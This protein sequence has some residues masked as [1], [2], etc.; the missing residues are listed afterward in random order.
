MGKMK[1]KCKRL[2]CRR[3]PAFTEDAEN[4]SVSRFIIDTTDTGFD[5]KPSQQ[6]TDHHASVAED[7]NHRGI[8]KENENSQPTDTSNSGS[9]YDQTEIISKD[10]DSLANGLPT[11]EGSDTQPREPP[12]VTAPTSSMPIPHTT[13]QTSTQQPPAQCTS[14]CSSTTTPRSRFNGTP[15]QTPESSRSSHTND[16]SKPQA[17]KSYRQLL[18]IPSQSSIIP[19]SSSQLDDL[20]AS[21]ATAAEVPGIFERSVRNG[22]EGSSGAFLSHSQTLAKGSKFEGEEKPVPAESTFDNVAVGQSY[23]DDDVDDDSKDSDSDGASS[24]WERAMASQK[25]SFLAE[26]ADEREDHAAEINGLEVKIVSLEKEAEAFKKRKAYVETVARKKLIHKELEIKQRDE[27]IGF[28]SGLCNAAMSELEDKEEELQKSQ[29]KVVMFQQWNIHTSSLYS[30]LKDKYDYEQIYVVAPMQEAVSALQQEVAWLTALNLDQEQ[31]I[32]HQSSEMSYVRGL[33]AHVQQIHTDLVSALSETCKERDL[34]KADFQKYSDLYEQTLRDLIRVQQDI[35]AKN[36]RLK[37]FNY[38]HED[39]PHPKEL[40]DLLQRTKDAYRVEQQKANECLLREQQGQRIHDQDK[41]S[42]KLNEERKQKKIE[43]LESKVS[44]LELSNERLMN[45]LERITT[46]HG[47]DEACLDGPVS[48]LY[49]QSKNTISELHRHVSQQES[50]IACQD[51]EIHQHKVTITLQTRMLEEKGIESHNLRQEI[52]DAVRQVQEIRT[53]F[54]ERELAFGEEMGEAINDIELLREENHKYQSQ[55]QKMTTSGIPATIIE[56][57]YSEI[58]GMQQYI[59]N[60]QAENYQFRRQQHEQAIKY[61]HDA[62]AA[63]GSERASKV[64]QLN[65]ENAQQEIERLKRDIAILHQGCDPQKFESAEQLAAQFA[66]QLKELRDENDE[67]DWNLRA[68]EEKVRDTKG[69]LSMMGR[70]ASNMWKLLRAVFDGQHGLLEYSWDFYCR[71]AK[72]INDIKHKYEGEEEDEGDCGQKSEE[73]TQAEQ[74]DIDPTKVY[75]GQETKPAL[76]NITTELTGVKPSFTIPPSAILNSCTFTTKHAV[77]TMQELVVDRSVESDHTSSMRPGRTFTAPSSSPSLSS[78]CDT[79]SSL[80]FPNNDENDRNKGKPTDSVYLDGSAT[81]TA[82]HIA[83]HKIFEPRSNNNHSDLEDN[84]HPKLYSM[85]VYDPVE[86]VEAEVITA[87]AF[88]FL[89]PLHTSL[90]PCG[91]QGEWPERNHQTLSAEQLDVRCSGH[92]DAF[93]ERENG[94]CSQLAQQQAI[95]KDLHESNIAND[96]RGVLVEV[97]SGLSRDEIF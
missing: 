51:E 73:N 83:E 97:G 47:S 84:D 4:V 50:Q 16:S 1:D 54:D 8:S 18:H 46:T 53:S 55:I 90:N 34:S 49:E 42:W 66:V 93:R 94:E 17:S 44:L 59:A 60:V 77:G 23:G 27:E 43:N 35:N 12:S 7:Y 56:M 32:A 11:V 70:L 28:Q 41:E 95:D 82:S 85:I 88:Q 62:D 63:A 87:A 79:S 2:F 3:K 6:P 36:Q 48:F 15:G 72:T 21:H 26:I 75:T 64:M 31:S 86:E 9:E 80:T 67:L 38:E 19:I 81:G 5:S 13:P 25:Q 96:D 57:H 22:P 78:Y 39:N 24:A 40:E 92:Y 71:I 89:L 68:A 14:S 45:D 37:D 74:V 29:Q 20:C 52:I 61:W 10:V 91:G 58:Q 33:Q 76:E 65:W 30:S 69:D